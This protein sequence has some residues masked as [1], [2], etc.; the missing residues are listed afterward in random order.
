M[1]NLLRILLF[2]ILFIGMLNNVYTQRVDTIKQFHFYSV[3]DSKMRGLLQDI[4]NLSDNCPS[5]T[6]HH[7]KYFVYLSIQSN[8]IFCNVYPQ[9]LTTIY[10]LKTNPYVVRDGVCF[11]QNHPI[12]MQDFSDTQFLETYFTNN[13][14]IIDILFDSNE[15]FFD[16]ILRPNGIVSTFYNINNGEFVQAEVDED[17]MSERCGLNNRIEFDY[18]V[19]EGD[20]WESIAEKC[21]CDV[22]N[23]KQEYPNFAT[24]VPGVVLF[25]FYIYDESRKFV[26][27]SN[28]FK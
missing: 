12:Y 28:P 9:N 7:K 17:E 26:R 14:S 20:T 18:M 5:F 21:G 1:K 10:H 6:A 8:Y 16:H 23:L 24:P 13:D 3:S 19:K 11:Y 2:Y 25:M 4:I 22:E 15:N 27:V